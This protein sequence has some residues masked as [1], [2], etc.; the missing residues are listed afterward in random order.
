MYRIVN[1]MSSTSIHINK[2]LMV[3]IPTLQ[4]QSQPTVFRPLS[5][6]ENDKELRKKTKTI[7]PKVM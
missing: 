4:I 6:F 2:I 3:P 1:L 7:V 5:T